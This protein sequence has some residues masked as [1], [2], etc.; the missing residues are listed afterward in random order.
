VGSG[1][2]AQL[3]HLADWL[4][5]TCLQQPL[6]NK[7]SNLRSC[8]AGHILFTTLSSSESV[9]DITSHCCLK[10]V[11]SFQAQRYTITEHNNRMAS[12]QQA[13]VCLAPITQRLSGTVCSDMMPRNAKIQPQSLTVFQYPGMTPHILRPSHYNP[14]K[15][16]VKNHH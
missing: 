16:T 1:L 5:N 2:D 13:V 9:S 11:N 10:P 7:S 6:S 4:K 3:K 14:L 8:E 12:D 15:G